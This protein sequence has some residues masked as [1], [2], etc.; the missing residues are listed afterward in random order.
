MHDFIMAEDSELWDVICD[1]PYVPRKKVGDPLVTMPKTRKEY[2]DADR[3]SVEKNFRAKKILQEHFKYN[4]DKA[5]KRNPVPDKR[6]K[7]KNVADN[8][9]KQALAAWGDS[10]SES[11]EETDTGTTGI[12]KKISKPELTLFRKT[13]FAERVAAKRGPGYILG[14]GKIGKS[15]TH[16]IEDVYYVNRLKYNL[17]IVSQICDKGNKV[18]FLS[19]ICTVTNLVTGKVVL[20]AK[21]YKNIYVADIESLQNGNLICLKAVDDEAELWHRRLGHASFSLLNKLVQKDLVHG[22]PKS[23]FAEHKVCDACTKGKHVKSSF[24]RNNL[25]EENSSEDG[26]KSSP[27]KIRSDHGTEFDNA[28]FDDFGNENGITH[29]FSSPITPQQNRV[30]ERKNKTLEE[31]ARTLLIDSGIAKNFWLKLSALPATW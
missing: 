4:P 9:V 7:R 15:L 11:E 26:L 27:H 5:A 24:K 31:M 19:K 6:F 21:R 30:V 29:N 13:N 18:E 3:K 28:K 14:V 17:L 2:N 23:K 10:S 8:V 22:L 25:C 20:V 16:T 12:S 1:G